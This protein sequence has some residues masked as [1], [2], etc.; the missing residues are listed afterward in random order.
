MLSKQRYN[1]LNKYPQGMYQKRLSIKPLK[2]NCVI[3]VSH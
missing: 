1:K 2:I 3:E